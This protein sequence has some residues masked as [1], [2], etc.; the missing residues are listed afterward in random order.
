MTK[1]IR[2]NLMCPECHK[3]IMNNTKICVNCGFPLKR[4]VFA[5]KNKKFLFSFLLIA[6]ILFSTLLITTYLNGNKK[7]ICQ[8]LIEEDLGKEITYTL[9]S[10]NQKKN[11]CFVE[12][13][14]SNTTDIA[15][16]NLDS[17][18][19]G[20]DSIMCEYLNEAN[21]YSGQYESNKY[22]ESAHNITSYSKL[23][24][25]LAF[26]AAKEERTDWEIIYP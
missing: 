14:Y 8:K 9:V 15:M 20:Y 19:I 24:D 6:I 10:Y 4:F 16:V 25:N 3:E 26:V 21:K 11:I 22:Q 1:F 5:Q 12:F 13:R 7:I 2:K 18:Q 23:Y 17:K